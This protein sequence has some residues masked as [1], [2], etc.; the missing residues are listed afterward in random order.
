MRDLAFVAAWIILVPLALQGPQLGVL[1]WAWTSLLAPND[2]LYG[3]GASVPFAKVTALVTL[4]PILLGRRGGMRLQASPTVL[5]MVA[6]AVASLVSQLTALPANTDNGWDLYQ[7]FV[8]ILLLALL[9]TALMRDRLRLHALLLAICLGIGFT[10]LGEGAKFLLSAG[11]HKVEGTASTGD[12]NQIGL[13]VLLILPMLHY[14]FITAQRRVLRG[15]ALAVG[16]MCVVCVVATASRAAFVGLALLAVAY[17]LTSRRKVAGL[18]LVAAI[19]AGGS[20]LVS[21]SYVD[22]LDTLKSAD[23]DD[24]FLGRVAAWKVSTAVALEHPLFGG[25]FHAIQNG[26]VWFPHVPAAEQLGVIDVPDWPTYPKAAHSIYF[27]ILGDQGFIGLGLFLALFWVGW[28]NA[29]ATRRV[30]RRS[31]RGDLRWATQMAGALQISLVLFLIVGG[32]LSAAY[33]DIDYLIVAMLAAL[34]ELVERSLREGETTAFAVTGRGVR[35]AVVV[36]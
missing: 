20:Q 18:L 17:V 36:G 2:V 8:K 9:V 3:L 14:L 1:L 31:G 12:N 29:G 23:S 10:G 5:I 11:G 27:E 33:Y 6:M 25:G 24:S 4:G 22:R 28:R 15:V 35:E 26:D 34:R 21:T 30:L 32:S 19:A 7:K 16:V 13:D